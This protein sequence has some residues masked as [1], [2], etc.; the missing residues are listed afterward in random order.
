[1]V[2]SNEDFERFYIRYKAE[3]LPR[4]ESIQ[5]FCSRNKVPFNL[6]NKWYKDTRH[7][8]VDVQV[9]GIPSPLQQSPVIPEENK[10]AESADNTPALR[11]M[12]DIR[13]TNGLHI[14]Q[15]DLSYPALKRMIANLEVL[16]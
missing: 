16:C 3:A 15:R 7:R 13:M 10:G 11:I 5:A 4:G 1:M 2:Y 8:V 9:D 12:I 14:R 6:F